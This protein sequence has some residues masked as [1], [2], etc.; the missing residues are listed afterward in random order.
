[1]TR[2]ELDKFLDSLLAPEFVSAKGG[3]RATAPINGV[4]GAVGIGMRK[5]QTNGIQYLEPTIHVR[6]I[7]IESVHVQISS[8]TPKPRLDQTSTLSRQIGYLE[9]SN[10]YHAWAIEK[11]DE[12]ER[13]ILDMKRAILIY[14]PVLWNKFHTDEAIFTA[15]E[16]G[17]CLWPGARPYTLPIVYGLT[18]RKNLAIDLLMRTLASMKTPAYAAFVRNW[19][20]YFLPGEQPP[21]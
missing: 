15:V 6:S 16:R 20:T 8:A 19:F 14:G 4:C 5:D 2:R 17:D 12:V 9:P 21:V 1:M 11:D 3:L 7:K 18:N 13:V 10:S